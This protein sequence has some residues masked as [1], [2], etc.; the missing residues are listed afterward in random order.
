ML[1]NEKYGKIFFI[2]T[3]LA[4]DEKVSVEYLFKFF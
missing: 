3:N 2:K 1:K 4:K